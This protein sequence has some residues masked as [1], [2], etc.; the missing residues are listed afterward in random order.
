MNRKSLYF[1]GDRSVEIREEPVPDCPPD[2]VII[3]SIVSAISAGT[4]MLFYENRVPE[5]L[6]TDAT[7]ESLQETGEFPMKYGYSVVGEVV[8]TGADV[9]DSWKGQTVFS[10]NPH[11]S[12]FVTKPQNLLPVPESLSPE[13]ALFLANTETAV[14]LLMD[15]RPV[16]G[17]Q[18]AVLGQG[19]V[20][21]LLTALLAR[22]PLQGIIT[23]DLYP[24]RRERSLQ[25]GATKTY[26]PS[27]PDRE[28]N[29]DPG[30]YDLIFELSGS[31]DGLNQAI[32]LAGFEGRVVIGSW[33]GDKQTDLNLGGRF[34]RSRIRLIS[35]QVSTIG[36]QYR[37]RWT[38]ERRLQT[39]FSL[40]QDLQPQ[41]LISH[42]FSIEEASQAYQLLHQH[43][44]ETIQTVLTY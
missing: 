8:R 21:L 20:G 1:T 36:G 32:Q 44:E 16:I 15:G 11:E 27:S 33:Y 26:D 38:K 31:P 29:R 17:E 22:F 23:F 34:H 40:L 10:L 35:S 6:R 41:H 7:I 39:A 4:E 5:D 13:D 43:P 2:Q 24:G 9:S 30:G 37:G 28:N 18:V 42:R 14:N 25:L 12:H 19:V 3:Q